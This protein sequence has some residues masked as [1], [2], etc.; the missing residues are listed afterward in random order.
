MR[1]MLVVLDLLP[2]M[3]RSI[4]RVRE[5]IRCVLRVI[6]QGFISIMEEIGKR[7]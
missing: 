4:S 6:S 5:H 7:F 1:Q 2:G 3:R